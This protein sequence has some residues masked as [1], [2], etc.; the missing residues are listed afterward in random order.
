LFAIEQ[1]VEHTEFLCELRGEQTDMER[2]AEGLRPILE[3]RRWLRIGRAGAPAEV[4]RHEW[5]GA[6][7]L[8][9]VRGPASLTLTSDL[10]VRDNLLRWR[11]SLDASCLSAVP[12]WPSNV[13]VIWEKSRQEPVAVHGF[14]GT[15]RL[16]R[17]P[18]SG[19]RRGSVFLVEGD[20][21]GELARQAAEGRW[22]GERTNEGFGRFRVDATLPGVCEAA[23]VVTKPWRND[24]PDESVAATTK[25]WFDAH[26]A[27]ADPGTQLS[28]RPSLSQWFD[29]V[30]DLEQNRQTALPSRQNPT[31]AGGRSWL[32]PDATKILDKLAKLPQPERE[33]HARMF[34]QWL[35]AKIRRK[36]T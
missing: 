16:W 13:Q 25:S 8:A 31:T 18:A 33:A 2:L 30:S 29:L 9:G 24:G 7:A 27:L 4:A 1:I 12:G 34:V 21:V 35:R 14:N 3:G 15:S 23:P 10:L 20:G 32:H 5:S 19:I 28:R 22:L 17:M 26:S 11:T 36:A 6:P